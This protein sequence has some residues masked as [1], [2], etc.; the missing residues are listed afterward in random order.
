V[1][2]NG[3]DR[4]TIGVLTKAAPRP[5]CESFE[6]KGGNELSCFPFRELWFKCRFIGAIKSAG[7][8]AST[9]ASCGGS[10]LNGSLHLLNRSMWLKLTHYNT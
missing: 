4:P 6:L 9:R 2:T 8:G 10:S 5:K 7:V 3:K 1:E